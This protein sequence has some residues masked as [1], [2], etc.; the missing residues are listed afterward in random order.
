MSSQETVA[1][2]MIVEAEVLSEIRSEATDENRQTR[3]RSPYP[4]TVA[5]AL[6]GVALA[7]AISWQLGQ[8]MSQKSLQSSQQATAQGVKNQQQIGGLQ[9]QISPLIQR[10]ES[11]QAELTTQQQQ[12]RQQQQAFEKLQSQT[13]G[14]LQQQE[15]LV[16]QLLHSSREQSR[17]L[18]QSVAALARRV[19]RRENNLHTAAALRLLQIAEEQLMITHDLASAQQ[20]LAQAGQQITASGDPILLPIHEL[21]QQELEQVRETTTPDLHAALARI[22]QAIKAADNLPLAQVTDYQASSTLSE[23][24]EE[25]STELILRKVWRDLLTLIRIDKREQELPVIASQSEVEM[26][27]LV[28]KLRLEQAQN[29]LLMRDTPLFQER[30]QNALAWLPLFDKESESVV[31][32]QQQLTELTQLQLETD[33]PTIGEAHRRLRAILAQRKETPTSSP[34]TDTSESP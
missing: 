11:Q 13:E 4:I 18:N 26:S 34:A 28:L 32:L 19:D 29:T 30:I 25:W 7:A 23:S 31:A 17:Q 10:I 15:Q 5:I 33:L 2:E 9:G 20:A 6:A 24:E 12:L 14:A 21:I 27:R 16:Q 8:T 22:S 1:E 3:Q